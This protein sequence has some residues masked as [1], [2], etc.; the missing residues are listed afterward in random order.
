[1]KIPYAIFI[2]ILVISLGLL[3]DA[4]LNDSATRDELAHIPAGYSYVR[5][6]DYR[7]NP[8]HPPLV[9]ALAALPL[10]A[11]DLNFPTE[12]KSWTEE[13]NSQWSA[14]EQFL[15]HSGNDADLIVKWARLFPIILTG[16]TVILIY[17][18]SKE[19]LGNW[20]GL[21][22][23]FLFGLSPTVLA[24]G[25]YVTTDIGAAFGALLATFAFTRFLLKPTGQNIFWGGLAFGVAQLTKFSNGLLVPF[26]IFLTIVF[27][28]AKKIR[29]PAERTGWGRY[30]GG[31]LLIFVIAL[32]LIYAVYLPFTLNYPP[33]KQLND[34]SEI[35]TSFSPRWLADLNLAFIKNSVLRPLGEYFLG[36]LMV[37]QRSAGGH[38]IYFLGEVS[39]AGWWYYFPLVFLMKEPIPSLLLIFLAVVAGLVF[40]A[41]KLTTKSYKLKALSDYLGLHF[42]E[43]S[44]LVFIIIYWGYSIWSP[45][46]IGVRHIL[47]TL[48]FIYILSAGVLKN[49]LPFK[50]ILTV[51][52]AGWFL[53]E[54]VLAWPYFLSYANQFVGGPP[55]AWK[56]TVDSNYDWGQDLKRLKSW[57]EE[58]QIEKIAVDYFGAGDP[59]FALGDKAEYWWSAK[60]TPQIEGI[61][62]LAVSVSTLQ[63][64]FGRLAP[65]QPRQPEDEYRWLKDKEPVAR[66][67]TSIFIY[68]FPPLPISENEFTP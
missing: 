32:V 54:T 40:L 11:F 39:A 25:H 57:A 63:G 44:M 4:N 22:P 64:A 31:L 67:G 36:F 30:L 59:K 48:P 20:W 43:F 37:L 2:L 15:Y 17:V 41:K 26:F 7:L 12:H 19:L 18:W 62:W 46:N 21:L 33:E 34:A 5:Y 60:G 47:P 66:A 53:I 24:H 8:E 68:S 49:R 52:V 42:P 14:G 35:L 38:T 29:T 1:M 6:L 55:N 16:L 58:N 65:G 3:W 23:A 51:I 61:E 50:K 45:L 9:K 28:I 13:V 10:L 27:L 56:Y